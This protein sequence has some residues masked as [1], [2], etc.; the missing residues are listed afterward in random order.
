M[1]FFEKS[2]KFHFDHSK[3]CMN[4]SVFMWCNR[5]S[6]VPTDVFFIYIQAKK[7]TAALLLLLG[8][9]TIYSILKLDFLKLDSQPMGKRHNSMPRITSITSIFL[10]LLR[11]RS[12]HSTIQSQS[13]LC[14]TRNPAPLLRY[15]HFLWKGKLQV[16]LAYSKRSDPIGNI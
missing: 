10:L 14:K 12:L 6:S 13:P 1:Q 5:A 16:K 2:Y 8:Y 11:K 9:K 7:L 15:R 4:P 3:P